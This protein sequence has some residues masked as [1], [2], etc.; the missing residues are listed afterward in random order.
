MTPA[1]SNANRDERCTYLSSLS[2][3]FPGLDTAS[4]VFFKRYIYHLP[5]LR[6]IIRLASSYIEYSIPLI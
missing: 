6:V 3:S 4:Y 2:P 1:I 5:S